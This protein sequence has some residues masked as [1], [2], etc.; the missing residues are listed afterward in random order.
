MRGATIC[1][2]LG[3]LWLLA[4]CGNSDAPTACDLSFEAGVTAGAE[5]GM[6]IFGKM[7][8]AEKSDTEW[9]GSITPYASGQNGAPLP[10]QVTDVLSVKETISGDDVTLEITLSGGKTITGTGKL[11]GAGS[12]CGI[13]DAEV[14][15]SLTGPSPGDT[16]DWVISSKDLQCQSTGNSTTCTQTMK[17]L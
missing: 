8:L 17:G 3:A 5:S 7:S 6:V 10:M 16:G 13:A 4:G 12:L 9:T 14:K 11:A 2:G 15:G 1:A